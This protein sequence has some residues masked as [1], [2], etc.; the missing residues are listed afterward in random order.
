[1]L[2]LVGN[3]DGREWCWKALGSAA[4]IGVAVDRTNGA[5]EEG[6]GRAALQHFCVCFVAVPV[7]E[8]D[9]VAAANS[10]FAVAA[11]IPGEANARS[12]I[13]EFV[14][15]AAPRN[16]GGAALDEAIE[17]IASG[18]I[19]KLRIV[20]IIKGK[21]GRCVSGDPLGRR[22]AKFLLVL[23]LIAAEEAPAESEVQGEFLGDAPI[24]LEVGFEDFVAV[25]KEVLSADLRVAADLADE[26]VGERIAGAVG[27]VGAET[28]LALDIVSR[29]LVLLC[30]DEIGAE[31]ESVLADDL[32]HSIAVSV[33]GVR[34]V[35]WEVAGI[36]VEAVSVD[37]TGGV[38]DGESRQFAA[39]AVVEERD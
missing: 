29:L 13:I 26:H 34:I 19:E 37:D 38:A 33:S 21:Q 5:V 10:P 36:D 39:E 30:R 6:Q 14:L 35:P 32:G 31:N 9:A 3:R 18:G 2:N 24:I 11:G 28:E 7:F 12:G 20:G 22:E 25:V 15:Q 17:K 27:I 1:P 23:F 16:P 8:E 4:D